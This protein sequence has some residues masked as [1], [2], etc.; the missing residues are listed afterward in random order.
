MFPEELIKV[1][2]CTVHINRNR[3]RTLVSCWE[4]EKSGESIRFGPGMLIC[5]SVHLGYNNRLNAAK[6]F[7][8]LVVCWFQSL[9]VATPG[10][11]NLKQNIL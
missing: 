8:K 1:F 10:S 5:C 9:A 3:V 7:S 11:I 4:E 2:H 6:M